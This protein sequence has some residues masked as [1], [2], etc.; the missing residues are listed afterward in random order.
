M[1]DNT[2]LSLWARLLLAGIPPRRLRFDYMQIRLSFGALV[3][4]FL[5]AGAMPAL[6]AADGLAIAQ[7]NNCMACHQVDQKRVGPPLRS[8]AKRFAG[9][10]GALDYL[11]GSI[12]NGGRG[13]WGAVPMPAQPQVS[14]ETARA[15]AAWILSLADGQPPKP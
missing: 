7:A 2:A 12:R 6:A 10:D 8:V 14:P 15:I 1:A 3:G 9:Q 11:A 5:L 4:A 13:R